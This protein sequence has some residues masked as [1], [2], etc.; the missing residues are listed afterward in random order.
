[1]AEYKDGA[2]TWLGFIRPYPTPEAAKAVFEKYVTTVKRDGAEVKTP[3][4]EGIDEFLIANNIGLV[5]VIFRKGNVIAGTNGGTDLAKAEAFARAFAKNVPASLPP[6]ESDVAG[7]KP[8]V[9]APAD[10]Q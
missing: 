3:K 7:A 5:D 4:V 1:M 8:K 9:D 10:Q 6:I 2:A